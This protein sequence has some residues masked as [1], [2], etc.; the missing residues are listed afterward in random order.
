MEPIPDEV[1]QEFLRLLAHHDC[2]Y[3]LLLIADRAHEAGMEAKDWLRSIV[4][5]ELADQG[6]TLK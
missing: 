5:A 3:A 4:E 1:Y 6:G 2:H